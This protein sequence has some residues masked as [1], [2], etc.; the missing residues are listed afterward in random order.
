[1]IVV[2]TEESRAH[3]DVAVFVGRVVSAAEWRSSSTKLKDDVDTSSP[4]P[5]KIEPQLFASATP[6]FDVS[7]FRTTRVSDA[8]ATE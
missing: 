5:I 2:R 7:H 3:A 1:M 6:D 8:N 4:L